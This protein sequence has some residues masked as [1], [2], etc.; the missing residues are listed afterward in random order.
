[1][2][3]Q[4]AAD[5]DGIRQVGQVVAEALR[6]T[7]AEARPGVTTAAPDEIGTVVLKRHGAR[8]APQIFYD[9]STVTLVRVN[10]EILHGLP[11]DRRLEP[12]DVVKL[13]VT[14]ELNGYIADAATTVVL[15]G[16]SS[17]GRR[18]RRC[19]REHTLIITS[20]APV[21]VTA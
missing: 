14:A 12:G 4:S 20:E 6:A 11:G 9:C 1:M 17:V 19:A 8:S 7:R 2:A 15:P 21:I 3:I 13:D 5:L 16:G 10:D 18:L